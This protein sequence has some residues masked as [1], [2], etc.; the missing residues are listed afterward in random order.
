MLTWEAFHYRKHNGQ[1][2]QYEIEAMCFQ[3]SITMRCIIL[4]GNGQVE[5]RVSSICGVSIEVS[6]C[7]QV[8]SAYVLLMQWLGG[9]ITYILLSPNSLLSP[10]YLCNGWVCNT[11]DDILGTAISISICGVDL[12]CLTFSKGFNVRA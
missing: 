8:S 5:G 2:V 9:W 12:L 7:H 3:V 6:H 4:E 1:D 10:T 11:W